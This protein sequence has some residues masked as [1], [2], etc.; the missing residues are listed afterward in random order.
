MSTILPHGIVHVGKGWCAEV[1]HCHMQ[2][3][4]C[5]AATPMVRCCNPNGAVLQPQWRGPT[6]PMVR[7]YFFMGV[8]KRPKRMIRMAETW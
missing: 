3:Q 6:T 2:P 4:W 7:C 5:G 8:H 1:L